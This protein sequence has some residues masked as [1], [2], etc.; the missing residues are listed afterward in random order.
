MEI[1]KAPT[2]FDVSPY[3]RSVRDVSGAHREEIMGE[4]VDIKIIQSMRSHFLRHFQFL[5]WIRIFEMLSQETLA[6]Y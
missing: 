1:M 4:K 6:T 2:V 3:S 5:S